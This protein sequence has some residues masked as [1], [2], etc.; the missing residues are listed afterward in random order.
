V[1]R[2]FLFLLRIALPDAGTI[3]NAKRRNSNAGA[4]P[5]R[6][7]PR[8]KM[9]RPL[10]LLAAATIILLFFVIFQLSRGSGE[11]KPEYDSGLG[12]DPLLDREF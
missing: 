8:T 7:A 5:F 4:R 3:M 10:R 6:P 9:F 1:I 11:K 2:I 12:R